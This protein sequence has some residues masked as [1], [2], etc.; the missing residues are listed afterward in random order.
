VIHD[1]ISDKLRKAINASLNLEVVLVTTSEIVT[2][3]KQRIPN[4]AK[5]NPQ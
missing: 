5:G 4:I 2:I 3:I 1:P